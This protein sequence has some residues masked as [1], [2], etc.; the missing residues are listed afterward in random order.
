MEAPRR[1]QDG[2]Q[3]AGTVL[4]ADDDPTILRTVQG[5]LASAGFR[6]VVT[7]DPE[8]ALAPS[9]ALDGRVG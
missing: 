3:S 4:V 6:A 9:S 1:S 5:T 7:V 2:E 8:E